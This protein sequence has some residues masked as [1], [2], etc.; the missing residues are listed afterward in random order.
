MSK[1]LDKLKD[2]FKNI[3]EDKYRVCE[4]LINNAAFM[5]ERLEELQ[6]KIVA[7]GC[8]EEY[9]NGANQWGKKKSAAV[10]V[11]NTMIKNYIATI[12]QLIEYLP[13]SDEEKA[14]ELI[15]FISRR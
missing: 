7:E 11:Y 13:K 4:S 9:Q 15:D 8:V 6:E 2:I 14:D 12:K 10:E 1:E 5:A 3:P